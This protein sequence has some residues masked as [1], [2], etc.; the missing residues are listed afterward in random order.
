VC[1]RSQHARR[2]CNGR[3]W[4]WQRL[5]VKAR[6]AICRPP[7]HRVAAQKTLMPQQAIANTD[8][9]FRLFISMSSWLGLVSAAAAHTQMRSTRH[10]LSPMFTQSIGGAVEGVR[11]PQLPGAIPTPAATICSPAAATAA[12]M[13]ALAGTQASVNPWNAPADNPCL[14]AKVGCDQQSSQC[15]ACYDDIVAEHRTSQQAKESGI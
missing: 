8:L 1:R 3:R 11:G 12:T 15:L 4:R 2:H 9:L 5:R 6:P 10:S 13:P 7:Q 14:D